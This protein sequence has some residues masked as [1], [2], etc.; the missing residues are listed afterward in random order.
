MKI[1]IAA[2]LVLLVLLQHRLWFAEG[3]LIAVRALE[4]EV[5]EQEAE[6]AEQR[7]RNEAL[8][9]EVADLKEGVDAIEARARN[10]L[11]MIGKDETFFQ[12]VEPEAV[13][14]PE[15]EE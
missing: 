4:Q 8:A 15:A 9:A 13:P 2:L 12:V 14:V 5:A 10:E 6:I 7:E 11:G 1:V 3:G